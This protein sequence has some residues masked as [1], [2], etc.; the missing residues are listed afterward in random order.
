RMI[1]ERKRIA[2]KIRSSGKG[3]QAKIDGKISKD[4]ETIRSEAYRTAQEIRGKA[5]AKS[6]AI[7][8][9]SLSGDLHFYEFV[10]TLEAYDRSLKDKTELI[11]STDSEFLR[12]LR[13]P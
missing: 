10:R 7:Y 4:L 12:Y 9:K 6:I 3:E 2:E 1:S 11:L 5:E 13:K 8:A